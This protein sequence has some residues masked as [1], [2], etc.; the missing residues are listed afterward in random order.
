MID[1]E[2]D[3]ILSTP[4]PSWRDPIEI[5]EHETGGSLNGW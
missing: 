4:G 5:R 2:V 3:P 1:Y